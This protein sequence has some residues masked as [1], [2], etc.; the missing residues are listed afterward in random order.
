MENVLK[1]NLLKNNRLNRYILY[2]FIY[3][4]LGWIMETLYIWGDI[5]LLTKRGF[6]FGP[7]CPIYGFGALILLI[8][9]SRFQHHPIKLTISSVLI[10][11]IFEYYVSYA[12]EVLFN[13]IWWDYSLNFMNING[14]ICLINSLFWMILPLM[15]FYFVHPFIKLRIAKIPKKVKLYFIIIAS[16]TLLTDFIFSVILNFRTIW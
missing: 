15:F 11:S 8:F 10:F 7:I 13:D 5:G 14:R 6:L 4:F 1:N 9:L 12:M 3:S 2:F 16:T